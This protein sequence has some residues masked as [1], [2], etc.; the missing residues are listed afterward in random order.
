[1]HIVKHTHTPTVKPK[2]TGPNNAETVPAQKE[3]ITPLQRSLK[4]E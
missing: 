4:V 3:G 1:M 2:W